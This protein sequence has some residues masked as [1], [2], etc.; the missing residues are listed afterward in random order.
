MGWGA[1]ISS[2]GEGHRVAIA[3][4]RGST[5]RYNS[6]CVFADEDVIMGSHEFED[7]GAMNLRDQMDRIYGDMPLES[8]P[9]HLTEPPQ[10]LVD[11]VATGKIKPCKAVDIGCG[12]GNYAVWLARQ[13]FD[14]TGFDISRQAIKH[15]NDLAAREGVSCRFIIADLL[16]DLREFHAAFDFAYDWE[17]LHHIFP[18]D[19]PR[20]IQNVHAVLRPS[21]LYVSLCF[22]ENDAAFGGMGKFRDTPL[23]TTLYFSSEQELRDLFSPLFD[24]LELRTIEIPGK[25][26]AHL[27]NAAWL[28]PK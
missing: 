16:G 22:S 11:A 9:W 23:G 13:G 3:Y 5:Q 21:A 20:Y 14:V 2:F 12:S 6:G 25:R 19:R 17:V 8:I 18:A 15:A 24:V 28:N 7:R 1:P 10:L 27:A 26:G 4:Q